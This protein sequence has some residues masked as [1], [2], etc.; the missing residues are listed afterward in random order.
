MLLHCSK[1][2]SAALA[3][4]KAEGGANRAPGVGSAATARAPWGSTRLEGCL[5]GPRER[6]DGEYVDF[7]GGDSAHIGGEVL[8]SKFCCIAMM[9][10]AAGA[11]RARSTF[12]PRPVVTLC[13][14]VTHCVVRDDRNRNMALIKN[15]VTKA[16][17]ASGLVSVLQKN[18]TE[19]SSELKRL[20]QLLIQ[21]QE[22]REGTQPTASR[23]LRDIQL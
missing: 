6:P 15:V 7:G 4:I 14:H 22:T 13:T 20:N 18:A 16:P 2:H 17:L 23:S 3:Q 21:S 8:L 11:G 9:L 5:L 10:R 1:G 12:V 19:S